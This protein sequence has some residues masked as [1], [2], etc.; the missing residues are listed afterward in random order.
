MKKAGN[1]GGIICGIISIIFSF[2]IKKMSIGFYESSSQYGGDAYT[3]IQNASAQAAN[4]VRD[5]ANIVRTGLFAFFLITGIALICFFVSRLDD[6]NQIEQKSIDSEKEK[7][8]VLEKEKE[9]QITKRAEEN[10]IDSEKE[11]RIVLEKRKKEKEL[12][13]TKKEETNTHLSS[14]RYIDSTFPKSDEMLSF[15]QEDF[16]YVDIACPKCD[17]TLS[18]NQDDLKNYEV[19]LCPY[20]GATIVTKNYR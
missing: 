15:N 11:K 7:K 17:E 20:C 16:R 3:G 10:N 5:L 6:N 14:D 1:I 4:N 2:D 9:H 13:N 12:Q 18:F 19:L 8:I